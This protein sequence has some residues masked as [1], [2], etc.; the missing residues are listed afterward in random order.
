MAALAF[1]VSAPSVVAVS[2]TRTSAVAAGTAS[3][4]AAAVSE[5]AVERLDFRRSRSFLAADM[6]M[7]PELVAQSLAAVEE[8]WQTQASLFSEC[9][10]IGSSSSSSNTDKDS[11]S[12]KVKEDDFDKVSCDGA[13]RA[14]KA[15]SKS[16]GTLAQALVHGSSG[17]K[18]NVAELL[19]DVCSQDVLKGSHRAATCSEFASTVGEAMSAN[20]YANRNY[21]DYNQLCTGFWQQL[22]AGEK[23]YRQVEAAQR[24]EEEK[25]GAAAQEKAAKAK[26]EEEAVKVKAAEA[27]QRKAD[28]E[29]K[30]DAAQDA[31]DKADEEAEFIA[32]HEAKDRAD[33]AAAKAEEEAKKQAKAGEEAKGKA[34]KAKGEE[35]TKA[36]SKV[37][38]QAN[39]DTK[40]KKQGNKGKASQVAEGKPS[41]HA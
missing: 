5:S 24:G 11:G 33:K 3:A 32:R 9:E 13:P 41:H 8:E 14:S 30:F 18:D 27:A 37:K 38:E 34:G 17:N 16:C 26:A 20:S 6:A 22:V 36:N 19:N 23:K 15:F 1:A 25:A 28:E 4:S 12:S 2:L 7:Q 40:T 31:K 35:N 39:E 29:A 21:I 10:N